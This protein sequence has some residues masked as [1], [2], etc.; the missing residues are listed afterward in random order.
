[1]SN[2]QFPPC[3]LFIDCRCFLLYLKVGHVLLLSYF[4][5]TLFLDLTDVQFVGTVDQDAANSP[6]VD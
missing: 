5:D 4:H 1:M 3:Y 6:F 2:L